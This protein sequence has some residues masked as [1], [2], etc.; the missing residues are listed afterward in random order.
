MRS[1]AISAAIS[2]SRWAASSSAESAGSSDVV[3]AVLLTISRARE[4]EYNVERVSHVSTAAGEAHASM[5]VWAEP[6]NESCSSLVSTERLYGTNESLL[7]RALITE[8]RLNSERLILVPSFCCTPLVPAS[9]VRSDPARSTNVTLGRSVVGPLAPA[10]GDGPREG[11]GSASS[12]VKTACERDDSAFFEVSP[13]CR[14]AQPR[15]SSALTSASERTIS[16]LA[17]GAHHPLEP[18]RFT[19]SGRARPSRSTA[20]RSCRSSL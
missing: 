8:P 18:L 13:T 5:S 19:S 3:M 20:R 14:Q 10:S 4:T 12:R 17:S 16:R 2:S 15:R 1:C 6:P 7:P 9:L 11:G